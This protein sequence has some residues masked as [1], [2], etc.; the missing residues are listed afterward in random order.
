MSSGMK[1]P[2][3]LYRF[4]VDN[5]RAIQAGLE[6]VL[7]S[8]RVAIANRQQN[9]VDTH[10]RMYAFLMGAWAECRLLKLLYEPDAFDQAD[11]KTILQETALDRWLRVVEM[12]FRR[13][14]RIKAGRLVPPALP[15]TASHRCEA[16]REV[17]NGN[18]R[19]VIV[20]RNKLAHGQWAYPLNE[21][22]N[23]VAQ[24]QMDALRAE[25]I[26]NLRQKSG[27]VEA[28][29]DAIHDLVVSQP[30][31]QRD[32]DVHFRR[33][34]QLR[35]NLKQKSYAQWCV[36]IQ[37]RHDRGRAKLARVQDDG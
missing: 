15:A 22:L 1:P 12:A 33:V 9:L 4:H 11:R 28:F 34:E 18:L 8:A 6:A 20:L 32:F 7:N 17:L 19:S 21:E 29:C 27:L 14:Y 24:E 16:L 2:E 31:F 23:D 5:L 3:K 36:Q 13:H 26:L 10:V 30:T 37:A 25:N 35:V